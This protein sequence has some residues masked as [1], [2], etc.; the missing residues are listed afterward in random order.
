MKFTGNFEKN[1]QNHVQK[2]F[3]AL[4]KFLQIGEQHEACIM[5][6][7]WNPCLYYQGL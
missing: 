4:Y 2:D 6:R 5:E 3:C 1:G 7:K